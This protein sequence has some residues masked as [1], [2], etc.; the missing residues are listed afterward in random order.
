MTRECCKSWE[1]PLAVETS[2]DLIKIEPGHA[3]K[4]DDIS[5]RNL[6]YIGNFQEL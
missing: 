1:A 6:T 3:N 5:Y 2:R 4:F